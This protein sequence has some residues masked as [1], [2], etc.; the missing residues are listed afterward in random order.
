M[1][2]SFLQPGDVLEF[3]APT[4]GV[5]KGVPVLIGGLPVVPEDTTTSVWRFAARPWASTPCRR[6]PAR[7]GPS[8]AGG[9]LGC[10]QQQGVQRSDVG[11]LP[12]G[13]IAALPRAPT[14]PAAFASTASR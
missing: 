1:G 11:Q 3:T 14:P 9:V 13:T 4:G 5:T 7:P 2:T 10:R 8:G 6:P 12:I